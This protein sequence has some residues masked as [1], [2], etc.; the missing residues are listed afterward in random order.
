MSYKQNILNRTT[1]FAPNVRFGPP[2]Y[3]A[4]NLI[5][6]RFFAGLIDF[7]IFNF[8][9]K[10]F[11]SLIGTVGEFSNY[12]QVTQHL[13]AESFWVCVFCLMWSSKW[14]GTFGM[15]ILRLKMT[16]L[17]GGRP[18]FKQAFKT[19]IVLS[20]MLLWYARCSFIFQMLEIDTRVFNL[21][22][23]IFFWWLV[24]GK[25]FSFFIIAYFVFFTEGKQ[26]LANIYGKT[27]IIHNGKS[28]KLSS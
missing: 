17:E 26:N 22:H 6:C 23:P 11:I 14:Q 15:K 1:I 3:E 8:L 16:N 5:C 27:K 13:L 7:F 21:E 18:D 24:K 28:M 4:I 9:H 19:Y 25:Y 2:S 20:I 10:I 12:Y